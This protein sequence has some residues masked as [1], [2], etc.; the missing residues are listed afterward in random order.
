VIDFINF[1]YVYETPRAM[2]QCSYES[3]SLVTSSFEFDVHRA[4]NVPQTVFSISENSSNGT[5]DLTSGKR[6]RRP[7]VPTNNLSRVGSIW[8]QISVG[9][10]WISAGTGKVCD[11][12]YGS[13]N[14]HWISYEFLRVCEEG[15]LWDTGG[16]GIWVVG[17]KVP[18]CYRNIFLIGPKMEH[19]SIYMN[20]QFSFWTEL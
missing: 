7:I 19:E 1:D 18:K 16:T 3:T 17:G 6:W 8:S 2:W 11:F 4:V 10:I 15:T 9:W 14:I 12:G 20:L 5:T 13:T